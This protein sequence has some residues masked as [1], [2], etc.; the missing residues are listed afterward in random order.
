MASG[1]FPFLVLI[2]TTPDPISPYS[3]EGTPVI[4]STDS[5]LADAML[6]VDT[7]FTS[8]YEA[9]F[10]S[11][12]PSTSTAVPK[13]ALPCSPVPA[14]MLNCFSDVRALDWVAP[15]GRR[16]AMSDTFIICTCSSAVLSIVREVVAELPFSFAVTTASSSARLSRESLIDRF[17]M[18]L[19]RSI[20]RVSVT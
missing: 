3:T 14:R 19:L 15:P 17:V 12:T 18:L 7:P 20:S 11:R 13:D 16:L 2:L 1:V 10:E 6:L 4:T 9:L 5:T 8:E